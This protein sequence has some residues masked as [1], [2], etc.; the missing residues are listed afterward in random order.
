M[1][2]VFTLAE[3]QGVS[4]AK[5]PRGPRSGITKSQA[6]PSTGKGRKSAT[7]DLSTPNKRGGRKLGDDLM[8]A[9]FVRSEDDDD[10]KA[11]IKVKTE[12]TGVIPS[13]EGPGPKIPAANSSNAMPS[14]VNPVKQEDDMTT[15]DKGKVIRS[16]RSAAPS[17]DTDG[18]EYMMDARDSSPSIG[19]GRSLSR[20]ASALS[21]TI[22]NAEY[23]A[24][25]TD[26]E[27]A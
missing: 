16:R 14:A 24:E 9:I 25:S 19:R 27:F 18:D 2:G 11:D 21:A 20:R 13:I 17:M 4:L 6:T 5:S 3:K 23:G 7:K 22:R 10:N 15:L 26:E 1:Q 8:D 12:T